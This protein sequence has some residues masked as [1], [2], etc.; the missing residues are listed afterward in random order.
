MVRRLHTSN[1]KRGYVRAAGAHVDSA[2]EGAETIVT[3]WYDT[4]GHMK[5][6]VQHM[7]GNSRHLQT[8]SR[9]SSLQRGGPGRKGRRGRRDSP[10]DV[11]GHKPCSCHCV[12]N[13]AAPDIALPRGGFE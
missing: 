4:N 7:S 11:R 2:D 8:Q 6:V 12:L 5:V 3:L 1:V 9:L 10:A 13:P